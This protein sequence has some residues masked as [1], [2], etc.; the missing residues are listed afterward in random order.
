MKKLLSAT[1]YVCFLFLGGCLNEASFSPTTSIDNSVLIS[2]DD[3]F[4]LNEADSIIHQYLAQKEDGLPRDEQRLNF[5][6]IKQSDFKGHF[7]SYQYILQIKKHAT[8]KGLTKANQK[9]ASRQIV[10]NLYTP[11]ISVLDSICMTYSDRVH[12]TFLYDQRKNLIKRH[13]KFGSPSSE[14]S[15]YKYLG[16]KLYI[17]AES[18]IAKTDSNFIWIKNEQE[19]I[20]GPYNHQVSQGIVVFK[21][22]YTDPLQ[23]DTLFIE[24]KVNTIMNQFIHGA[25]Q[26]S[27]MEISKRFILPKHKSLTARSKY[28]IETKGLWRMQNG[29]RMGGPYI[30]YTTLDKSKKN[31]IFMFSYLYGPEIDKLP[32]LRSLEASLFSYFYLN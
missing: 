18:Y 8:K 2:V 20:K 13:K 31:I 24:Q 17:P 26:G 29:L 25:S 6:L 16:I 7:L 1:L 4:N 12:D 32:F 14:D 9:W 11:K 23:L 28:A 22:P 10:L 19:K 15:L 5:Q 3:N 30:G 21:E 27:F